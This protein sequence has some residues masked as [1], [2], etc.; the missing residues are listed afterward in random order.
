MA[1]KE[2]RSGKDRK[3][4]VDRRKLKVPNLKVPEHRSGKDRR[5]GKER[6]RSS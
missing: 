3:T 4:G 6:R 5:S 1:R 2:L